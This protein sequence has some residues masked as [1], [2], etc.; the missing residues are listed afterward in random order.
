LQPAEAR[1]LNT[2]G[3]I[4]KALGRTDEAIADFRRSLAQP[5]EK[6]GQPTGVEAI[7][8]NSLYLGRS[9]H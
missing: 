7:E 9:Q 8:R 2:R 6:P 4:F 5:P 3:H 1:A